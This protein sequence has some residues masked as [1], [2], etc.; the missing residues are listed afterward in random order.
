M[1]VPDEESC[2]AKSFFHD[3]CVGG[4]ARPPQLLLQLKFSIFQ[5]RTVNLLLSDSDRCKSKSD[6]AQVTKSET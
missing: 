1:Y 5:S 4:I 6:F 3:A 2:F